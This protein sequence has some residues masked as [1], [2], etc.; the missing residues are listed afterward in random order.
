MDHEPFFILGEEA[1]FPIVKCFVY[2]GSQE[3]RIVRVPQEVCCVEGCVI[4][5]LPHAIRV[6]PRTLMGRYQ[7]RH[8][9]TCGVRGY[10]ADN[11]AL[12]DGSSL[13]RLS[14]RV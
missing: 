11:V 14:C 3:Q 13:I 2:I 9:C 6:E 7:M 10:L 4:V 12:Q 1:E 8:F 5:E